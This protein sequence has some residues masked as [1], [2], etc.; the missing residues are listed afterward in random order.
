[1]VAVRGVVGVK[2]LVSFLDVING[3]LLLSIF[4]LEQ[5][6][7]P[8][9]NFQFCS[10]DEMFAGVSCNCLYHYELQLNIS[11]LFFTALIF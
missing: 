1:M 3:W 7:L 2:K 8:A 11:I 10:G 9:T 5:Y 6:S 4:K